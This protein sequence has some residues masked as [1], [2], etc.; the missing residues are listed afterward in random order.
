MSQGKLDQ[1]VRDMDGLNLRVMV[2][3]SGGYGDK[4]AQGVENMKG[5]YKD[6][7]VVFANIDFTNLD[8]PGYPSAPPR[9]WSGTSATAP[10]G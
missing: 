1:L 9:N 4:L 2:N 6:R 5:R 3:L 7:F 10:R 8:D